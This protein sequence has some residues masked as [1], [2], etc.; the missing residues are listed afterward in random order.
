MKRKSLVCPQTFRKIAGISL[1]EEQEGEAVSTL[2]LDRSLGE[3]TGIELTL[4]DG[5]DNVS[6]WKFQRLQSDF[7]AECSCLCHGYD[8]LPLSLRGL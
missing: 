5:F 6:C 8:A 7:S 2:Q 3:T 1:H 4:G